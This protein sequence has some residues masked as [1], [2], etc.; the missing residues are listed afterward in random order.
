MGQRRI[1]CL[2]SIALNMQVRRGS[3]HA[4]TR[5]EHEF[6]CVG[7]IAVAVVI[8]NGQ[9]R[10]IGHIIGKKAGAGVFDGVGLGAWLP[11][12]L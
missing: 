12:G 10:V 11:S 8:A 7:A 2:G 5:S 3:T 4:A 6:R 9:N 1:V